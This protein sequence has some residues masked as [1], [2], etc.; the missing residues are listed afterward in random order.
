MTG[1]GNLLTHKK[2]GPTCVCWNISHYFLGHLFWWKRVSSH[3]NFV[4]FPNSP[5]SCRLL[6]ASQGPQGPRWRTFAVWWLAAWQTGQAQGVGDT[7][8]IHVE[9]PARKSP[10][11][12][13]RCRKLD[14]IWVYH[15]WK[16]DVSFF[17]EFLR[18]S[19]HRV[20]C[21]W[22]GNPLKRSAEA[23]AVMARWPA[24]RT[25]HWMG[26]R[27][28]QLVM[29]GTPIAGLF[30]DVFSRKWEIEWTWMDDLGIAPF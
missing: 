14:D 28:F 24:E 11:I 7:R 12:S 13:F 19:Q 29:G 20:I 1:W 23:M 21:P 6:C 30:I 9:K 26:D 2:V 15:F 22:P 8:L 18:F 3:P 16:F 17:S 10:G 4:F 25:W 5:W 27:G